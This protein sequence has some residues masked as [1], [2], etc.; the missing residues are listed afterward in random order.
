[1]EYTVIGDAV[2][3]ASRTEA[4]NKPLGTDILITENTYAL[5]KDKVVV[6]EMPSVTV[7]GKSAPLRMFAVI[8]MP[9]E[10]GIPGAGENGPK[11]LAQIRAKLGI[12]T[13]DLNKVDVNED[14]KKY[15]IQAQNKQ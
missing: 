4:L 7:K 11:T 10:T 3:L 5:V 6:E 14:E 1:M 9:E 2:N 8:N 12:P 13:P 15:N